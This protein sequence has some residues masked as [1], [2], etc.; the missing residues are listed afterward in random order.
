MGK[1]SI[2]SEF[3]RNVVTLTTGTTIAQFIP[4]LISPILTRLYSPDDF[5]VWTLYISIFSILEILGT[6][7]FEYSL[8]LPKLKQEVINLGSWLMIFNAGILLLCCGIIIVFGNSITSFFQQPLTLGVLWMLP[9]GV[10]FYGINQLGYF[11]LNRKKRYKSMAYLRVT[12]GVASSWF[13][14][15]FGFFGTGGF[16]LVLANVLT[17]FTVTILTT[18]MAVLGLWRKKYMVSAKRLVWAFKRRKEF[19]TINTLHALSD[20]I[21]SNG[22]N[23]IIGYYYPSG[24]LGFYGLTQRVIRTPVQLMGIAVSEV[25]Y[26]RISDKFNQGKPIYL[27]VRKV[28][29]MVGLGG[30]PLFIGLYFFAPTL[31][32]FV[33]GSEWYI[34]GEFASILCPWMWLNFIVNPL[35]TI[36]MVLKKQKF[37]FAI[38]LMGNIVG[39][40]V[41]LVGGTFFTDIKTTFAVFSGVMSVY[42][43]FLIFWF[44][45]I[46]R[47]VSNNLQ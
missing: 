29:L 28:V 18:K 23:L 12:R 36:P 5:A 7:R 44:L 40:L 45:K 17:L 26:Q 16:G 41:F 24:F 42:M 11:W 22:T 14:L 4:V 46:S 38:C 1:P 10:F 19:P 47:K 25:F 34:A 20:K 31:M 32:G 39:V 13:Q 6:G 9:V 27:L 3:I 33:F 8:L 2:K 21:N 43:G 35:S 30:L 15:I 37:F